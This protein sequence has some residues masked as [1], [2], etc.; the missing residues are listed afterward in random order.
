MTFHVTF[1]RLGIAHLLVQVLPLILCHRLLYLFECVLLQSFLSLPVVRLTTFKSVESRINLR[2]RA[3]VG[4]REIPVLNLAAQFVDLFHIEHSG[5]HICIRIRIGLA[6]ALIISKVGDLM[7]GFRWLGPH[8]TLPCLISWL[9]ADGNRFLQNRVLRD[10]LC[11]F[12]VS[13]RADLLHVILGESVA[14]GRPSLLGD[15]DV[16]LPRRLI[17]DSMSLQSLILPILKHFG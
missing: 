8:A 3:P 10:R 5:C 12:I 15:D 17:I 1:L 7:F 14:L 2:A 6:G 4:V 9:L 16:A 13:L 11:K